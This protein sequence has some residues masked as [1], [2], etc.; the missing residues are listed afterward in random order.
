MKAQPGSEIG[1]TKFGVG[2]PVRRK[3]D[4]KLLRGEGR[5]T[6]D[7][8]LPGQLHAVI[9][10]SRVAH[11][12]LRGIDTEAAKTMPGV[13][14]IFTGADLEAGA[15]VVAEVGEV[16][17]H[18]ECN[19]HDELSLEWWCGGVVLG[20]SVWSCG[21]VSSPSPDTHGGSTSARWRGT[22]G[23][24]GRAPPATHSRNVTT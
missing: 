21:V 12:L 10:R 19:G 3:E 9:V 20:Q 7:V 24:G 18:L 11:G 8:N 13:H 22:D 6:D 17:D 1:L 5:Y 15:G 23:A 2:Q 14:G 16:A 4:P